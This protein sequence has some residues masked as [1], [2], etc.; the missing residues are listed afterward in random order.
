MHKGCLEQ[1]H[2]ILTQGVP[3]DLNVNN[4]SVTASK[5]LEGGAQGEHLKSLFQNRALGTIATPQLV[6][7]NTADFLKDYK[8]S[9]EDNILKKIARWSPIEKA[10]GKQL[11]ILLSKGQSSNEKTW[12]GI[13]AAGIVIASSPLLLIK[14]LLTPSNTLNQCNHLIRFAS[15]KNHNGF[16]A[17]AYAIGGLGIAFFALP[18]LVETAVKF[19]IQGGSM[20]IDNLQRSRTIKLGDITT[21]TEEV[22]SRIEKENRLKIQTS[23]IESKVVEI[24]N[25]NPLK[26]LKAADEAIKNSQIPIF[27][28]STRIRI[29][30]YI[31][32]IQDATN[33]DTFKNQYQ[34]IIDYGVN[35]IQTE[36]KVVQKSPLENIEIAQESKPVIHSNLSHKENSVKPEAPLEAEASPTQRVNI[37]NSNK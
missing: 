24:K 23:P 13:K 26:A 17:G 7:N 34:R 15:T 6:S 9:P 11:H 27:D 8:K 35:R 28:A 29:E 22:Q 30:K 3:F 31:H 10:L 32:H 2:N 12:A 4:C 25:P 16:K 5:I 33:K 14:G 1:M 36:T 18:A 19:P 21:P 20:I 37:R